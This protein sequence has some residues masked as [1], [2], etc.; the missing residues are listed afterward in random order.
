[1]KAKVK[2]LSVGDKNNAYFHKTLKS[3]QH[4]NRIGT[5]NDELGKRLKAMKLLNSLFVTFKSSL[6]L[7]FLLSR[8]ITWIPS[9]KPNYLIMKLY[10]W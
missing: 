2:W 6:V 8:S 3:R 10:I 7:M 1:M 4:K 5:I 9:S